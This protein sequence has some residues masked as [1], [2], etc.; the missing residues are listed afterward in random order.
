MQ[1]RGSVRDS[2]ELSEE[3]L[4]RP[5]RDHRSASAVGR[6]ARLELV[7]ERR[8]ARTVVAHAYAEPPFRIGRTFDLQ[9]AAYVIIVCA[10]PGIFRRHA[11]SIDS[12]RPRARR[13][14]VAGRAASPSR[15]QGAHLAYH[16]PHP[17][18]LPVSTTTTSSR[19]MANCTA[20]GIR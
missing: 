17:P 20:S 1:L 8:G 16:Q 9:G 5:A 12:R 13:P 11:A 2:R 14:H 7:F 15:Q 19:T 3:P 6:A 18:H 4:S 10:G